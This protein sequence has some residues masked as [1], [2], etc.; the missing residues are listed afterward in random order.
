M[1]LF[2]TI[3]DVLHVGLKHKLLFFWLQKHKL[4]SISQLCHKGLK[5]IFNNDSSIIED[6]IS[7]KIKLV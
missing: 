6:E 7:H 3:D 4:L 1:S 5:I 2:T